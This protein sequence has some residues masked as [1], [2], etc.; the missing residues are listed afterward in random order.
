MVG[1]SSSA[2]G[3]QMGR[4]QCL[5]QMPLPPP[6]L[7]PISPHPTPSSLTAQVKAPYCMHT[8]PRTPLSPSLYF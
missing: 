7:T 3:G 5:V 8:I 6:P 1:G 2:Q 4:I